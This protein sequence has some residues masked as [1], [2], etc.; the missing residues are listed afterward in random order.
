MSYLIWDKSWSVQIDSIDREHQ[1]LFKMINDLYEHIGKKSNNEIIATLI[2]EMKD[3]TIHHFA[4]EETYFKQFG[5][6]EYEEHKAQHDE[7]VNKVH[8]LEK[9]FKAGRLIL[10]YEITSF[11]KDWIKNH[12]KGTDTKYITFMK[13]NGIK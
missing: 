10:S 13:R 12:I 5:Y 9:R 11:L 7:F 3:Y 1:K 6:P 2:K 8:D 4:T